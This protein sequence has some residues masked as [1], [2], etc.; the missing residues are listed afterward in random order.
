LAD[1]F[2]ALV[3]ARV[4]RAALPFS[5]AVKIILEGRGTQFDPVITDCLIDI[6]EDFKKIAQQYS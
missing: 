2:D 1:V 5:E 4:Y 3:C 6:Q